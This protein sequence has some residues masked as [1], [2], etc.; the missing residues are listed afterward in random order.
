MRAVTSCA[1]TAPDEAIYGSRVRGRQPRST[2]GLTSQN[3]SLVNII[4]HGATTRQHPG[5][6]KST[7]GFVG[8]DLTRALLT[9]ILPNTPSLIKFNQRMA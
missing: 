5:H 6:P 4:Y 2:C 7:C 8:N 3:P 1:V 9:A